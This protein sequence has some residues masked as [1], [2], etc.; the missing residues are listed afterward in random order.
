MLFRS[1][2][3]DHWV[4]YRN[5][6][7]LQIGPL[8]LVVAGLLPGAVLGRPAALRAARAFATIIA[9][10]SV[11]GLLLQVIPGLDQANGEIIALALPANAGLALALRL[12]PPGR[13]PRRA[14]APA[15]PRGQRER[16]APAA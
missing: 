4:T 16:P 5:E 11:A 9:A 14:A 15:T 10:L 6:N 8:A 2:F 13:A 7:V 12:L 3:T 1:G